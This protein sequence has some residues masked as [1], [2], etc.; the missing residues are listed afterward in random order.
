MQTI[1]LNCI[2]C[3][4]R[5]WPTGWGPLPECKERKIRGIESFKPVPINDLG[6]QF[7]QG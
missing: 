7:G 2:S 5:Y 1:F 3:A 6:N 4:A